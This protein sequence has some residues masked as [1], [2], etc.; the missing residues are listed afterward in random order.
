MEWLISVIGRKRSKSQSQI[1]TDAETY[2]CLRWYIVFGIKCNSLFS[3]HKSVASFD[4]GCEAVVQV[5]R[6]VA[7]V[8]CINDIV[9]RMIKIILLTSP[10]LMLTFDKLP[11][12]LCWK[13]RN[14]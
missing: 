9:V 4:V 8:R 12:V 6:F 7:L 14:K 1:Y 3:V 11:D 13:G 10:Q 2:L 5:P